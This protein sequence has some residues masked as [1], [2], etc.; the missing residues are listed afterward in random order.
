MSL[1]TRRQSLRQAELVVAVNML[2]AIQ[3]MQRTYYLL[4]HVSAVLNAVTERADRVHM[5][6]YH[7]GTTPLC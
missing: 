7:S 3:S 5:H 6:V 4:A 2:T 1:K